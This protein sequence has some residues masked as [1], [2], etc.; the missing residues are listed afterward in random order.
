MRRFRSRGRVAVALYLQ[1]VC[2]SGGVLAFAA[3]AAAQ[4]VSVATADRVT[5]S[6][7]VAPIL[8]ANCA[9]C[10]RPGEAA[11]FNLLTYDDARQRARQIA[12]SVEHRFMPPWKPKPGIGEFDNERRLTE[13]EIH[14][15][16]QWVA[17]G[18]LEGDP[19]RLPVAPAF[20][21]GWQLGK[22]D[23]IVTM[24]LAYE[25]QGDGG[26][27]F[28]NF[29]LPVPL[30]R[31][32]WISAIEFR[33]GNARAVHHARI[34][35]DDT[36][37][38]RRRDSLDPAPGF[39]GMDVPGAR[40]PDGHFLGWAPGKVASRD[41]FPWALEPGSDLVVQMHMKPTGRAERVQ[42]SIG[43]YFT[44][45]P[46]APVPVMLRL[47]SKTIDIPAGEARHLVT[48]SY[49]MPV[50]ADARR[51]YPARA[52]PGAGDDG[53]R[54]HAGRFGRRAPAHPGLGLQLAGR[55][56]V[57][58]AR[59]S[60]ARVDAR[61]AVHVRQLGRRIRA[62]RISRRRAS[63]SGR[64]GPTRWGSCWCSSFRAF[65]VSCRR[66]APMSRAKPWTRMS[67]ARRSWL[68]RTPETSRRGTAWACTT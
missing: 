29:V 34:L 24:P 43:L 39:G 49:T 37:E 56:R 2:V 35:I 20:T 60:P 14:T 51:I 12:E 4:D 1:T 65:R 53:A 8:L 26:D 40:F 22:P 28:R 10:H 41:A 25:L 5:Y 61:H 45:K 9:S 18:T 27:V 54:A 66:C 11:P 16:Q 52:L 30:K 68:P 47:G 48:D 23:L 6:E 57:P 3:A 44:N 64:R 42:A 38:V 67:R 33:P 7:D 55:L 50:D 13:A 19:K 31:S 21:P 32:Q 58:P 36:H 17:D 15:L 63:V 62:T 46:P 59:V